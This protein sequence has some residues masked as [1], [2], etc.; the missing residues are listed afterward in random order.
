MN[1]FHI[2]NF[3]KFNILISI[4]LLFSCTDLSEV[5]ISD[6]II[7]EGKLYKKDEQYPFTGFV[8]SSYSNGQLE[9]KGKYKNGKPNGILNYWYEDGSKMREGKLKDGNPIG[10]W[11]YYN[12]DGSNR[13]TIDY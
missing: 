1:K 11:I 13:K 6:T 10:R 2:L 9:Y 5:D 7:F 3:L 4:A 8:Y 12:P